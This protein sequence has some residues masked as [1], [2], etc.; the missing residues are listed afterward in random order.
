M[1][2]DYEKPDVLSAIA[3]LLNCREDDLDRLVLLRRSID[4]RGKELQPRFVLSV[5]VDY[6]GE[7]APPF[8]PGR[9]DLAAVS[10]MDPESVPAI[11]HTTPREPR[12]VVVGAG[13]A[14]L[15]AALTL[16]EAGWKPLIIERGADVHIRSHQV[17]TFWQEGVLNLES[18]VLYGEGGA[19]LF[20]DGKLTAR[21]KDRGAIK[22]FLELLV[23]CGASSD[24]LIDAE[25]HIGSDVLSRI[26]PT[27]RNR[28][29][30][31]GGEVRFGA[32][33][34]GL[35]IEDCALRGV[36]V[37]G[38][39]IATDICFLATGHSARDVYTML[40]EA[41]VALTAKPFAVGVRA[42]MPQSRLNVAQYGT[43]AKHPRLTGA[44]F[45]LTRKP[46]KTTRGC[47]SFCTCPGGLV[48]ACAS[49]EG[50]LT[51]NGMSYSSRAKPYGNAA[52][53]VP[54][55]PDDYPADQPHASL[56][57]VAL[58]RTMEHAAFLAGGGDYGL[59]AEPLID[60]LENREPAGIPDARSCARAVPS[61]IASLLPE[62]VA[63]MLRN[64]L[65][66]MLREL[67]GIRHE[68]VL[69][70][71]VETRSSSPVRIPRDQ[72]TGHSTGV[73]GLYPI[74]EGSGYTG[75][76]VSSALDGMAAARRALQSAA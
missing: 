11:P 73:S 51:T 64:A 37:S 70:Y 14:G 53:L 41:G 31:L 60:F 10:A 16:A 49:S 47:Y 1:K 8:S 76:I 29:E 68:D 18:N 40:A 43:W 3:R 67:N 36:T 25:P 7:A 35:H 75:G 6:S 12:P 54:V 50:L 32:K 33:L 15:M 46:G 71:G 38:E 62:V 9:V 58:Q 30:E 26:I 45:R 17:E 24:I 57:G 39:E 23:D 61:D 19:G 28:I 42:E 5:E 20:S 48:M 22:Q 69:L 59:P 44:S 63:R 65:P 74:G 27:L 55:G 52:F 56:A 21:S 13:P 72:A 4:A 66:K 2:L 34:D